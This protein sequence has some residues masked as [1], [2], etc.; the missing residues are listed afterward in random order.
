MPTT[1]HS[2]PDTIDLDAFYAQYPSRFGIWIYDDKPHTSRPIPASVKPT[3]CFIHLRNSSDKATH[4]FKAPASTAKVAC[5]CKK[6]HTH[7]ILLT[8]TIH[9]SNEQNLS[10]VTTNHARKNLNKKLQQIT[11]FIPS[12]LSKTQ[13][14]ILTNCTHP[15]TKCQQTVECKY[16][17]Q[18]TRH[19]LHENATY[20]MDNIYHK[21][22]LPSNNPL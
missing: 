13:Q 3:Q 7:F 10:A 9:T 12:S 4:F 2:Q 15:C 11:D 14:E 8:N 16:S 6:F 22:C 5:F 19:Y 18:K 1:N 20:F 21:L 17:S